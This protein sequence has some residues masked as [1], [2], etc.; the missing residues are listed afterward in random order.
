MR[1][2]FQKEPFKHVSIFWCYHLRGELLAQF[3]IIALHSRAQV[4][5][6]Q[7]AFNFV[8]KHFYG[9]S[10]SR[11]HRQFAGSLR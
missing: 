2:L 5:V 9:G 7:Q 8:R 1:D 4:G 3:A 6:A 11:T 10:L